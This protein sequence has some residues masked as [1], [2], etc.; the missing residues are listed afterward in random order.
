MATRLETKRLVVRT[1][2]A[3]DGDAWVAMFS[4]PEITRFLP[5][6]NPPTKDTF[7]TQLP[8]R[9]AM[10][11]ELGHAM[12]AVEE[13]ATGTF[14]GQCGLRPAATMDP[15]AGAEIDLAY[16]LTR[17]CWN[18]GYAS[19]A[20]VAVIRH[21]LGSIG[22]DRVM[23]VALPENVGSWRVME[24]AGMR[25]EG[26]AAYYGLEGLRSTAQSANG[27]GRQK[28]SET[29]CDN[30]VSISRAGAHPPIARKWRTCLHPASCAA[31]PDSTEFDPAIA[32]HPTAAR[33][34]L[35]NHPRKDQHHPARRR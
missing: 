16:H 31:R 24:K 5:G 2:E 10:E 22:L 19:E 12:W 15:N 21:G 29:P 34:D 25:Y 14:I 17:A 27:G 9:H 30:Q 28:P 23:A 13:K 6:A 11:A 20:V 1:F 8:V 3:R 32:P 4:D 18:K 26:I 7:E 35:G 33:R